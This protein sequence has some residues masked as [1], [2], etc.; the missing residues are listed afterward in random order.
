MFVDTGIGK[1]GASEV[2]RI[3][4]FDPSQTDSGSGFERFEG[5]IELNGEK[6]PLFTR[7]FRRKMYGFA[8][9]ISYS[10]CK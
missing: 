10:L 2:V 9:N 7:S 1:L 6:P 5:T 3:F 4:F 8:I